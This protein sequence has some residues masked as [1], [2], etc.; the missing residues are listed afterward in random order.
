MNLNSK[1]HSDFIRNADVRSYSKHRESTPGIDKSVN[2]KGFSH[3]ASPVDIAYCNEIIRKR[4]KM[5]FNSN[6][7]TSL[8]DRNEKKAAGCLRSDDL[9][10][11]QTR[12]AR[13]NLQ[14]SEYGY[15]PSGMRHI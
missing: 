6:P 3:S 12:A 4:G 5:S 13:P 1:L 15:G 2:S 14:A 9:S 10:P 8:A 11:Y 7:L